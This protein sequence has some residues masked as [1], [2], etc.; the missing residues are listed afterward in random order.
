MRV[1][2]P[3]EW[4]DLI[5]TAASARNMD[6]SELVRHL[7]GEAIDQPVP[8]IRRGTKVKRQ[9][10]WASRPHIGFGRWGRPLDEGK[11]K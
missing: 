8:A 9:T 1:E 6:P 10:E 3:Q 4:D 11:L 7:I 2:L 5:K